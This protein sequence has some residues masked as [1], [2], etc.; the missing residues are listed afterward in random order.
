[1]ICEHLPKV[2]PWKGKGIF[3]VSGARLVMALQAAMMSLGDKCLS[4]LGLELLLQFS[5]QQMYVRGCK[6]QPPCVKGI[7]EFML[8]GRSA[9]GTPET[10]CSDTLERVHLGTCVLL[11]LV[12]FQ[13]NVKKSFYPYLAVSAPRYQGSALARSSSTESWFGCVVDPPQTCEPVWE[14][15]V[16]RSGP[17]GVQ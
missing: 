11:L 9:A 16:S 1:M 17:S 2:Q 12:F 14:M 15:W 7:T 13:D 3:H 8:E 4:A 6:N 10:R 5:A